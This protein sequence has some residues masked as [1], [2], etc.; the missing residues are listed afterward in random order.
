MVKKLASFFVAL[1]LLT[2]QSAGQTGA[3]SHDHAVMEFLKVVG[4][5]KTMTA[6]ANAVVQGL[7]QVNPPLAPY[8]DIIAKWATKHITW[9]AAAPEITKIYKDAFTEIEL[10]DVISFYKTPTGQK[11]LMKLPQVRHWPTRRNWN[12][13]WSMGASKCRSKIRRLPSPSGH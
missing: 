13:C 9:E 12:S 6:S 11:V 2:A 10:R 5:E 1:L 3:T 8:R 4:I 7:I